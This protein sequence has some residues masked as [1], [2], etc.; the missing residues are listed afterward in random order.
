VPEAAAR[1]V[2]ADDD[3]ILHRLLEVHFRT[4]GI[5]VETVH[6][7]DDALSLVTERP[8]DALILDAR[9]PGLDGP[10]VYRRLR[11]E[12]GFAALPVIFLTGRSADELAD[13]AGDPHV[14]VV[15]KPFDPATLLERVRAAIEAPA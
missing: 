1:V 6:R 14:Q 9:M 13:H 5:E 11:A 4:A 7:G 2:F 12:P 15:T 8:P 3:P 10:E